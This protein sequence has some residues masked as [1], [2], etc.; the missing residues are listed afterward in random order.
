MQAIKAIVA[1]NGNNII[2]LCDDMLVEIAL[3]ADIKVM[4][5]LA[6]TCRK[7]RTRLLNHYNKLPVI[8]LS[9]IHE[10]FINI[11]PSEIIQYRNIDQN[12]ILM[13]PDAAIR[14]LER[15]HEE[16]Y[17]V[18]C[19]VKDQL[20]YNRNHQLVKIDLHGGIY[21]VLRCLCCGKLS[22]YLMEYPFLNGKMIQFTPTCMP[23]L[24]KLEAEYKNI[25]TEYIKTNNITN[26]H[27]VHHHHVNIGHCV[28]RRR[29]HNDN[30]F[31][32]LN[33]SEVFAKIIA[34][35]YSITHITHVT[36]I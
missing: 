30:E 34:D 1:S 26:K 27:I 33:D 28:Y 13:R 12:S 6:S 3:C 16:D 7:L 11:I 24:S 25:L 14:Q 5:V 15:L 22:S 21:T 10:L 29:Y 35:H 2:T 32:V 36:K 8:K 19:I 31:S 18:W 20:Q 4:L 9:S 17:G 23:C